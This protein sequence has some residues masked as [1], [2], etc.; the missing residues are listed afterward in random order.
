MLA[1]NEQEVRWYCYMFDFKC[2]IAWYALIHY[3]TTAIAHSP[4]IQT[5]C[6]GHDIR[7][8]ADVDW[9]YGTVPCSLWMHSLYVGIGGCLNL[10]VS[11]LGT[12]CTMYDTMHRNCTLV[13]YSNT[14]QWYTAVRWCWS[15]IWNGI[16][17]AFN[18]QDVRWYWCMFEFECVIAW[19]TMPHDTITT[20]LSPAI[21]LQW[22]WHTALRSCWLDIWNGI[23]LVLDEQKVRWYWCVYLNLNMWLRGSYTM[24]HETIAIALSPAI[25]IQWQ[26]HTALRWC[27][28]NI[29]IC[30]MLAL[31][32]QAVRWYWCMFEFE[33][34]I[35]R[36]TMHCG[37][38]AIA[39]SPDIQLQWQ[40]HAALR[41]C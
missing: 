26:W 33:C 22:Q 37:T 8:C 1:L 20:A 29:W 28:L 11:L 7:L 24:H 40:W 39:H 10:N 27:W 14:R 18:E 13:C 9:I 32:G 35:A 12:Q 2:V 38:I 36:Y 15:H 41:W 31:D 25:Q 23:A 21:Q 30:I 3:D 4:A 5:H 19:Y 17:L 34:V 6:N 16:V